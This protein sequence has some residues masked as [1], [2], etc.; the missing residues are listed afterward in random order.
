[1]FVLNL[2]EDNDQSWRLHASEELTAQDFE[3]LAK[4]LNTPI[5]KPLKI[6]FVASRHVTDERIVETL[7]NGKET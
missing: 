7:W 2:L 1:M 4:N 3:K 6:G 5:L